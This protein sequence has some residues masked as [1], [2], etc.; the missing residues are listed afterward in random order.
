[1]HHR[2]ALEQPRTL[3]E[4][5]AVINTF[6]N[7]PAEYSSTVVLR[8]KGVAKIMIE[9]YLPLFLLAKSLTG[10]QSASLTVDSHPGPD[11]V[12]LFNDGSHATVQITCAGE[13]EGTALQRE[14]LEG[15][16][17]VYANQ[18]AKR[19]RETGKVTQSGRMLT[20]RIANTRA[21]INEV[22]SAIEKKTHKY[23]TATQFLLI[24]IHRSEI[25]MTEDWQKQLLATVCALTDLPY[26][27]TYVATHHIC[28]PLV[29]NSFWNEGQRI[30]QR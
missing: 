2:S 20:T 4:M 27:R 17:I 3:V 1:M 10:F 24:S 7:D 28:F 29:P 9:E 8:R 21:A 18:S 5:Q 15:G 14:L 22:L 16:Q 23:R 25:T 19:I 30:N 11:A 26:E 6:A 13:N 12:L